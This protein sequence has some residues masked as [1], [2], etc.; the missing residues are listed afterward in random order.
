[1]AQEKK[2]SNSQRHEQTRLLELL[3]SILPKVA[4]DP[5][6]ADRIYSAFEAELRAKNRATSFEKF[7]ER[8]PLPD[9]EDA[10]LE[11]VKAELLAG[12]GDADLEIQP[13]EDG[14]GLRVD[15]SLPDGTQMRSRIRVRPPGPETGDEQDVEL[16]FVAFPV[17]LPGDPELIWVLAK[18]E[19]LTHEEAG[20]A[21]EKVEDDFW[22]SRTGQKLIRDRVEKSFPEF[23]AR[24]PA[25]MLGDAGLKRHHKM[26]ETL[27]VL[28]AQAQK[29]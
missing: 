3:R 11:A 26:P 28:R 12:F 2:Q 7:C 8:I 23:I 22:A 1:M 25:G 29:N 13:N 20:R 16:K 27:K 5:A 9:L 10:T 21:L 17:S 6:L 18:R 24:V 4:P 14:K 19:N 15:V